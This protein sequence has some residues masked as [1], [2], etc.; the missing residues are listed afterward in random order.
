MIDSQTALE[1]RSYNEYG[2]LIKPVLQEIPPS[3]R[4]AMKNFFYQHAA[5]AV[6]QQRNAIELINAS[7]AHPVSDKA[8]VITKQLQVAL[9]ALQKV[10]TPANAA[11]IDIVGLHQIDSRLRSAIEALTTIKEHV[12]EK[13]VASRKPR[14]DDLVGFDVWEDAKL[15]VGSKAAEQWLIYQLDSI[16]AACPNNKGKAISQN[17]RQH[18]IPKILSAALKNGNRSFD[19]V[20]MVLRRAINE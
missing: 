6:Q 11:L 10:M 8:K 19:S 7:M 5:T 13:F 4:V 15:F 3:F 14:P 20:R 2:V 18:L 9:V 17:K 1:L 12:P 16:L